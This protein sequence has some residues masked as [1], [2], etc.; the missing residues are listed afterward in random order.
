MVSCYHIIMIVWYNKVYIIL[1]Q[2]YKQTGKT[3]QT[4]NIHTHKS[5]CRLA[6]SVFLALRAWLFI[7]VFALCCC[8]WWSSFAC[9]FRVYR[10]AFFCLCFSPSFFFLVL[11]LF[12]M[13]APS[14]R[15]QR[16]PSLPDR[17]GTG[18]IEADSRDPRSP[19]SVDDPVN[20]SRFHRPPSLCVGTTRRFSTGR[21]QL[22][23]SSELESTL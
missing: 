11:S 20:W 10:H 21:F 2:Y 12:V 16:R 13:F 23:W 22:G 7:L 17:P 4:N 3:H 6:I 18:L 1:L 19:G 14:S 9:V 5:I 15:F 8:V